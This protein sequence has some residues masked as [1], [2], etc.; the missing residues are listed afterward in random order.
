MADGGRRASDCAHAPR[1]LVY[2]CLDSLNLD[3]VRRHRDRLPE[4]ARLL[5]S[6]TLRPLAS[7]ATVASASVWPTFAAEALPGTHGEYFPMQ[8]DAATM[9]FRRIDRGAWAREFAFQPF[10]YALARRGVPC[11]VLDAAHVHPTPEPPCV[12]VVNWSYQSSGAAFSQPPELLGEL[13]RRFGRRPIGP[14]V[15]VPKG[16]RRVRGIRDQ[17]VAAARA[18]GDAILWLA[19]RQPWRFL[20]AA[21]FETHR[22]GHNLWPVAAEFASDAEPEAMLDVYAE[23]DRQLGRLVERLDD[24]TTAIV[25]FALHGMGVNRA[26]DH[27]LPAILARANALWRAR[28]AADCGRRAARGVNLMGALRRAV[29]FELQYQAVHW[30][31]ERVQ[32]WVVNRSLVGGLDWSRTPAFA[33]ASGGEGYIRL[34]LRGRERDG[35]LAPAEA[36][37]FVDF[38]ERAL[39]DLRV[40]ATGRRLVADVVRMHERFPG[41]RAHR[42]PDLVARWVPAEPATRVASPALGEIAARLATGRGGNHTPEA[43][44]LFTGA[45]PLGAALAVVRGIEDLGRYA[46]ACLDDGVSSAGIPPS[47]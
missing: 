31:G 1:R 28:G 37:E 22:A 32:D 47:P 41:P 12:Q 5:A 35:C 11:V 40:V 20:L 10:W 18:K 38:L 23:V 33:T 25:V 42:L 27:F 46:A 21:L 24:G 26:Q 30:L 44:A 43:F 4:L 45:A 2:F 6:A 36:P 39:L 17:L 15:P 8:W 34:N 7:P 13:R 3:F 14:E 16:R 9:S 19:E 29:P